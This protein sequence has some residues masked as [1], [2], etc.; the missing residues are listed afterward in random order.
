MN[1]CERKA[2]QSQRFLKNTADSPAIGNESKT[3][4]NSGMKVFRPASGL[5]ESFDKHH[6]RAL[7]PTTVH[8]ALREMFLNGLGVVHQGLVRAVVSKLDK[9][10]FE[11][12]FFCDTHIQQVRRFF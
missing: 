12:L 1:Q 6:G 4:S 8:V 2:P 10:W 9:V 5:Y 11:A 7:T 3:P